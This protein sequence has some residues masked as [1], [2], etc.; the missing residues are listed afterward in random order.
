MRN[1]KLKIQ[2]VF[3]LVTISLFFVAFIPLGVSAQATAPES[4]IE[5]V[6]RIVGLIDILT[7]ILVGGALIA[8][9]W[10]LI[11]FIAAGGDKSSIE[12][13]REKIKAGLIGV[14]VIVSVWALVK[15]AANIVGFNA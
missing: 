3:V 1:T 2:T 14:L 10:G 13:G 8:F 9:F 11:E 15:L 7:G 4:F 6:A 12:S 5:L